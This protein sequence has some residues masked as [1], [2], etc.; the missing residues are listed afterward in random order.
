MSILHP[1]SFNLEALL[2]IL[3]LLCFSCY[4][5]YSIYTEEVLLYLH[6][7]LIPFLYFS[8]VMMSL[9]SIANIKEFYKIPRKK[10]R[11]LPYTLFLIPFLM[12]L[13]I[14][15]TPIDSLS[16]AGRKMN[17]EVGTLM[18]EPSPLFPVEKRIML[19]DNTFSPWYYE[20]HRDPRSYQGEQITATGFIY[21]EDFLPEDH[22]FLTRFLMVCCIADMQLAGIL[23]SHPESHLYDHDTWVLLQGELQVYDYKGNT[24]PIIIG[25]II[26]EI[27]RPQV[28]YVYPQKTLP[29]S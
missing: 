9:I 11:F 1:K 16:L 20:L 3:L 10:V 14:Y 24:I 12:A 17:P 18:G 26:E 6:P 23:V 29:S 8:T 7:R 2:K 13:L 19:D 28:P 4:I 15:P 22:F 25:E 5:L 27:N 21:R